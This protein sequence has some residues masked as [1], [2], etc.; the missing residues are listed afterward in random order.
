MAVS[1]RRAI[2]IRNMK[3]FWRAVLWAILANLVAIVVWAFLTALSWP[4]IRRAAPL[5]S[6][7]FRGFF[8]AFAGASYWAS[9]LTVLTVPACIAVFFAWLVLVRRRPELESTPARRA[10]SALLLALPPAL[11]IAVGFG[12]PFSDPYLWRTAA[13][14][15]PVGL[16]SCW[17]G[18]WLP[19]AKMLGRQRR[20]ADTDPREERSDAGRM[21]NA[22]AK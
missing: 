22:P 2:V 12:Y 8:A 1:D 10:L 19:R 15:F 7:S 14:M 21:T 18:V 9:V 20:A 13:V 6:H 16:I 3:T 17:V 5:L 11:L 4:F